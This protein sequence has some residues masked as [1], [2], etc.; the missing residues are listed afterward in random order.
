MP[1]KLATKLAGDENLSRITGTATGVEYEPTF[2]PASADLINEA[3][4]L[5]NLLTVDNLDLF[6]GVLTQSDIDFFKEHFNRS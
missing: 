4:T 1:T 5:Q 3:N 6:T 2:R